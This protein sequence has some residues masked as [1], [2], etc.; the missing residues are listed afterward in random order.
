MISGLFLE[1]F[2]NSVDLYFRKFEFNASV[3]YVLRWFGDL[4]VG[5]NLIAMFG[6]MLGVVSLISILI[7][8]FT[9]G[10]KEIKSWPLV[11]LFSITVYLC[12]TTTV[13]P[14]YLSLPIVLCAFTT[15]RFPV[16]W[17]GL[18][19]LT[20]M[21]YS[22]DQYQEHLSIV[23][24]EYIIVFSFLAYEIINKRKNTSVQEHKIL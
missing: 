16:V 10:K 8:A 17:S 15:Y 18:I 3:F 23:A 2:G 1:N 19:M 6:P 20:Y 12:F 9:L 22:A 4:I 21:N 5:Y 11:M 24:I 7:L 13:H 14:W